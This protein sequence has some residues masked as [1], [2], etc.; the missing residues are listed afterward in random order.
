M[1]QK[2]LKDIFIDSLKEQ[3]RTNFST[4]KIEEPIEE[5]FSKPD[6]QKIFDDYIKH[7]LMHWNSEYAFKIGDITQEQSFECAGKHV[8]K[9]S[10]SEVFVHFQFFLYDKKINLKDRISP[11]EFHQALI[12]R[13][14]TNIPVDC[15][16]DL[17]NINQL[18][19]DIN[20]QQNGI[21]KIKNNNKTYSKIR[22]IIAT[23]IGAIAGGLVHCIF[24]IKAPA[25]QKLSIFV[26][27]AS[28]L[29]TALL[30]GIATFFSYRKLDEFIS[31]KRSKKAIHKIEIKVS[32]LNAA[33]EESIKNLLS[34]NLE[35][36]QITGEKLL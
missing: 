15:Y 11:K 4:D 6:S 1:T 25:Y 8:E 7:F 32:N 16:K 22:S 12:S 34:T 14:L 13:T 33:R 36:S 20:E 31:D 3:I 28:A 18:N 19:V 21:N 30:L 24:Q 35:N 29:S 5:L 9:L 23:A 26:K 17:N 2:K 27:L 10:I